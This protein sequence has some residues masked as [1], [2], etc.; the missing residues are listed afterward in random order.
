MPDPKEVERIIASI[1]KIQDEYSADR[2]VGAM[3]VVRVE[4]YGAELAWLWKII[5]WSFPEGLRATEALK[6]RCDRAWLDYS[7]YY[8]DVTGTFPNTFAK[9]DGQPL[10]Q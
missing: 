7:T 5:L 3:N 8:K 4:R 6:L 2:L 10:W 1:D 9:R